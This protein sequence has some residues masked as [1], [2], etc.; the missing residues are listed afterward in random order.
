M[1]KTASSKLHSPGDPSDSATMAA[2]TQAAHA[3]PISAQRRRLAKALALGVPVAS[4]SGGLFAAP[5]SAASTTAPSVASTPAIAAPAVIPATEPRLRVGAKHPLK[6]PSQA[7]KVARDGQTIE[8]DAGDYPGDVASWPQQNLTLRAVQGRVTLKAAGQH[9]AGKG[10]WV[11][12]GHGVRVQG[13]DFADARVPDHNG[14]GIRLEGSDLTVSDCSFTDCENGLLSGIKHAGQVLV[15]QCRFTRCGSGQGNTHGVYVGEHDRLIVRFS[16]FQQTR[17]GHHIKSRALSTRVE[18]CLL[19]DGDDGTSSY[20]ID[21]SHGGELVVLGCLIQ[22]GPQSDNHAM[23]AFG[24]EGM[25]PNSRLNLIHNTLVVDRSNPGIALRSK[26]DLAVLT[27][28]N[29][30][31]VGLTVKQTGIDALDPIIR[32]VN[33]NH[34]AQRKHF[35]DPSRLDYRFLAADAPKGAVTAITEPSLLPRFEPQAQG[36]REIKGPVQVPGAFQS[37]R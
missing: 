22:E 19:T 24:M 3:Q 21:Q 14:A 23:L 11:I 12:G 17:V 25:R 4:H 32:L 29:N 15:E 31:L 35:A 18:Y 8:I 33:H 7:A 20:A 5:S 2:S 30:V 28:L 13:I 37:L 16:Q 10:I 36:R 27:M 9:A 1:A 6:T 34:V 26:P